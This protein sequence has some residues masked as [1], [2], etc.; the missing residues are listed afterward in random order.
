MKNLGLSNSFSFDIEDLKMTNNI[1]LLHIKISV[2]LIF[3]VN[4]TNHSN[5]SLAENN[6]QIFGLC[7]TQDFGLTIVCL[8]FN[9]T[10]FDSST[11]FKSL[12]ILSVQSTALSPAPEYNI[13]KD[14]YK[15]CSLAL[16]L[17]ETATRKSFN[18]GLEI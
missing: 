6:I 12:K 3:I 13:R 2:C 15:I 8:H 7:N 10:F 9:N 1:K 16:S 14:V 17:L 5:I 4:E 18:A 11:S